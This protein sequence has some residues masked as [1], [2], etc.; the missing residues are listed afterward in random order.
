MFKN[1]TKASID[2]ALQFFQAGQW[3][4]AKIAF[5]QVLQLNPKEPDALVGLGFVH[6]QLGEYEAAIN[7]MTQAVIVRPEH[8]D[9]Q[10]NFG[11]LHQRIGNHEDAVACF[12][13]VLVLQSNHAQACFALGN[14]LKE[15]GRQEEASES[16][17]R[18]TIFSPDWPEAHFNLGNSFRDAGEFAAAQAS[19][20]KAI[21]LKPDWA[22]AHASLGQILGLIG[23]FDLAIA[24]CKHAISLDVNLSESH[25]HLAHALWGQGKRIEAL[26][27]YR[28]AVILKPQ[29]PEAHHSLGCALSCIGRLDE[30]ITAFRAATA[31]EPTS[32]EAH[33]SL[34]AVLIQKGFVTKNYEF[35][36]EADT[37]FRHALVLKPN[38][39]EAHANLA[40][41]PLR[42]GLDH[43]EVMALYERTLELRPNGLLDHQGRLYAHQCSAVLTPM[44]W[45]D[46]LTKFARIC[47]LPCEFP[48]FENAL[49][50][51]KVLRVGYISPDF[52]NHSCAWFIEPL[53]DSHNRANVEIYCYFTAFQADNVT[54]R[55]KA[56]ADHWHDLRGMDTETITGLIRSH[57]IDILV[58]LAGHTSGNSLSVLHRK[59]APVQ[60]TWLGFPGSTGLSAID[61]RLSDPWLTPADSK[62]YFSETLIKLDRPSHCYRPSAEAPN[63]DPLPAETNNYLTFGSFNN[64][65]KLSPET[66]ALWAKVLHAVEYS[67]LTLKSF[68]LGDL[69]VCR[70]VRESF[71][72][73]GIDEARLHLLHATPTLVS[74]LNSYHQ[75]DIALDTFPYNGATTSLEALWMGVP[76]ISLVGW[77]TASR[78][79]LSFLEGLGLGDL[80]AHSPEQFVEIALRLSADLPRLVQ[81][82]QQLRAQMK[83]SPLCDEV[84]FAR[85]MEST[86][87]QMWQHYCTQQSTVQEH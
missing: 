79:G 51:E 77:R 68:Q 62:E 27:S 12:R 31:L 1:T 83:D 39:P 71:A 75:I 65:A 53:L 59:A 42:T 64:L 73:Q 17:Q 55:L 28:M 72:Q 19:Y 10:Y 6:F 44:Q 81:L 56:L 2:K 48:R 34:G 58:D 41:S 76:V 37:C 84:G 87:R 54:L 69:E 21:A 80:A 70:Q 29:W 36:R 30:A 63:V 74:H 67:Q 35:M 11:I 47:F 38:W 32:A 23:D 78:Y 46:A 86:Y 49:D 15:L 13:K 33:T 45:R 18:A 8:V 22:S 26:I 7:R 9:T 16:F 3:Q 57:H 66:I 5:E 52:R 20:E 40:A 50:P 4:P 25:F 61:Y 60:S 14:T 85:Q 24:S 82:R 43:S